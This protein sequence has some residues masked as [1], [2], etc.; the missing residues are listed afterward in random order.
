MTVFV[1]PGEFER[2]VQARLEEW[3]R[4]YADQNSAP[5]SAVM[6]RVLA[7]QQVGLEMWRE[8]A[9][10]NVCRTCQGTGLDPRFVRYGDRH[11][12]TTGGQDETPPCPDCG[13]ET[14]SA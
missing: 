7:E 1:D 3:G 2:R 6:D 12:Y 4:W 13:G 9:P 11:R 8:K 5:A 10:L 14:A